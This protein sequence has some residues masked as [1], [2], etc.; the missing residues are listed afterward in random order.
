MKIVDFGTWKIGIG[1]KKEIRQNREQ[2]DTWIV[3]PKNM[4]QRGKVPRNVIRAVEELTDTSAAAFDADDL[5]GIM[6]A[7]S[8]CRIGVGTGRGADMIRKAINN[9]VESRLFGAR[10]SKASGI[11]FRLAGDISLDDASKAASIIQEMTGYQYREDKVLGI[12]LKE[13]ADIISSFAYDGR[14]KGQC[15]VTIIAAG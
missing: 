9:A 11:V 6:G 3:I 4:L 2:A 1:T 7:E 8:I 15:R 10:I 14:R 13:D 12:K 5:S